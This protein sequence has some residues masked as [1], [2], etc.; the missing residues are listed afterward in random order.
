MV[1]ALCAPA[2]LLSESAVETLEINSPIGLFWSALAGASFSTWARY[3]LASAVS[4]DLMA[5]IRLVSA[6]SKVFPLLLVELAVDDVEDV[7]S[8][9]RRELVLCKLEISM[10]GNPFRIVFSKIH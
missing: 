9:E 8:S 2:M 7:A 6:L 10:N 4:P 1:S 5:D 3:F